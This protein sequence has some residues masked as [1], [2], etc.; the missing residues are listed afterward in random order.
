[1]PTRHTTTVAMDATHN[2]ALLEI[3]TKTKSNFAIKNRENAI[4]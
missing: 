2:P 1:M 3:K 4:N